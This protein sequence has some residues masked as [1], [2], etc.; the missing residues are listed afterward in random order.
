M[1]T[2]GPI[3]KVIQFS[4]LKLRP[5]VHYCAVYNRQNMESMQKPR[6]VWREDGGYILGNNPLC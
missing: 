2:T 6:E 3:L 1:F 5:N 4:C